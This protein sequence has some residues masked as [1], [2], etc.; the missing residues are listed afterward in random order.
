M[1]RTNMFYLFWKGLMNDFSY[2]SK[3]LKMFLVI[4]ID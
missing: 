3:Y 1:H 2:I 4:S